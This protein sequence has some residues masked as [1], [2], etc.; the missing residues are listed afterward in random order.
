MQHSTSNTI[1]KT[2]A[3]VP[4]EIIESK[5]SNPQE[6]WELKMS[7]SLQ[8]LMEDVS[9]HPRIP[10]DQESK[11]TYLLTSSLMALVVR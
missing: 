6:S 1:L 4:S 10:K 5:D 7:K 11:T 8:D 9:H 3:D 2:A